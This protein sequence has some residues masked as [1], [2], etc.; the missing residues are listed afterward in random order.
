MPSRTLRLFCLLLALAAAAGPAEAQD[1]TGAPV[2]RIETGMHGA[3]INRLAVADQ[4]RQLITVSDD[5]T[6]RSWALGTGAPQTVWRTP[7]GPGDIGALY[8]VAA[9]GDTI[10]AG[11]RTSDGKGSQLYLLDPHSGRLRGTIGGFADSVSALAFSA[12]GKFLAVGQQGSAGVVLIDFAGQKILAQDHRYG[13]TVNF[14]AFGPDGSLASTSDDGRIRLYGPGLTEPAL[15][16]MA[17]DRP[18]GLGFA[19]DG[20]RLAVGR[21]GGPHIALYA[22]PGLKPLQTL[23]GAPGRTGALSVVSWRPDGTS[24]A[25]AGSYKDG[26]GHRLVR[27]WRMDGAAATPDRDAPAALDTVTDLAVLGNGNTVYVS[28]EPSFGVLGPDG[29]EHMHRGS[30]HVDFRDAWQDGFRVSRDGAVLE[31]PPQPGSKARLRFDL[32]EGTLDAAAAPRTDLKLAQPSDDRLKLADWRNGTAPKLNGR[33]IELLPNE[34]VRSAAILPGDTGVALGSDFYLRL[35]RPDREAWQQVLPAPAWSVDVSGDGKYVL[36]ALGDGTIR[37]YAADDGHQIMSLFVDPQDRRWVAWVP[38]GYFDHSR[39]ANGVSGETLVGYH[40]SNGPGKAADF[41]AIGQ[42]YS[43]FYRRDLVLARFRGE[44]ALDPAAGGRTGSV[45]SVLKTGLP[46]KLSVLEA[47]VRPAGAAAC[48]PD[49]T[50]KPGSDPHHLVAIGAGGEFFARY[51]IEDQGGGLGRV[52]V[53]RNGAAIDGKRQTESEDAK[54][55]RETV[56][57]A[58]GPKGGEFRFATSSANG[59]IQ[60]NP[61]D[62]IIVEAT[63]APVAV[64]AD[65]VRGSG[66][67]SSGGAEAAGDAELFIVA[68]G[69]SNYQ[70]PEFR[71]ANAANDAKAVG[72]M[73]ERPSPPVYGHAHAKLLLDNDATTPNIVAALQ[74]IA[75]EA[76][77][78][79]IIVIYFSGHGEA[80]DGQYYFAPV[81]FAVRHQDM[82]ADARNGTE[83]HE[84]EIVADLFRQDGFGEAQLLPLLEKMQGNLLL[85]LDT[86]Y[87]AALATS[88]A[89]EQKARNETVAKS[90][91]HEIGRFILAGARSEALD[92]SGA[93]GSTH[94]L[95]T[96]YLLKGLGGDADLDHAG[97]VNVAELLLFTKSHVRDASRKLNL[98]QEPF[99][100]F[101]GSNFFDVRAVSGGQ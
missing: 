27:F 12:D 1:A 97:R 17:D 96:T 31:F 3:V 14:L 15:A 84:R 90:V 101:S 37:W 22:I 16:T 28:A 10:V 80:I 76:R 82:L 41:V 93:S 38:E 83:A 79:D 78:Q 69:V 13:G 100:Y 99:Y 33:A 75:T 54:L 86:C 91:G 87:S 5:K 46:P 36:A 92:S 73:L 66:G 55:R 40:I 58:L 81:D 67:G 56:V 94:G 50:A 44:A 32:L 61:T 85:V 35:E 6:A 95:F 19:P 77:P 70:Q 7:I 63:P 18:W 65:A 89:I 4:G 88:D 21:A 68:I 34:H 23:D 29:A 42:L 45:Q 53:R 47:C 60:S 20:K 72:E 62:D 26:D 9:A 98:E 11:G 64:A 74:S 8:A 30:D 43:R 59:A 24:L 49:G 39:D 2:L 51:Q 48:P 57:L 25:A 52:T 71:L